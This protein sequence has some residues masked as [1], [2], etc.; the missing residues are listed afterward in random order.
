MSPA[1][2]RVG[3]SIGESGPVGWRCPD[4]FDDWLR[5]PVPLESTHPRF[6]I[7]RARPEEFEAIYD[8]VDESFGRRR[9]RALYE[10]FYRRNPFGLA[11]CWI[12][13]DRGSGKI[14]SSSASWPW[15]IAHG[16][17]A[18]D[19]TLGADTAV[20]PAWQRLGIDRLRP[21]VWRS[22]PWTPT[23]VESRR[24]LSRRCCA[25]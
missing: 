25:A 12:V 15:P 14:V 20:A 19:G 18:V 5:V 23:T 7:R 3:D 9:P 17:E 13:I 16:D 10:W 6:D 24:R 2:E 11:R 1:F 21:E 22:H 4:R 8:L